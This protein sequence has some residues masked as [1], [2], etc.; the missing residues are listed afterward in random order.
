MM[1]NSLMAV[2]ATCSIVAMVLQPPF[3]LLKSPGKLRVPVDDAR[4]Q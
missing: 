1:I 2:G 3:K 4:D